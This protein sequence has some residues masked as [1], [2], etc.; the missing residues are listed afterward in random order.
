MKKHSHKFWHFTH[1]SNTYTTKLVYSWITKNIRHFTH[2]SNTYTT[3]LIYSWIT[4]NIRA[5]HRPR[6]KGYRLLGQLPGVV[7]TEQCPFPVTCHSCPLWF[8]PS[9]HCRL[10]WTLL[11]ACAM[12]LCS[13]AV[14]TI[15]TKSVRRLITRYRI[16]PWQIKYSKFFQSL[17]C[18]SP[19][20]K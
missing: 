12:S 18:K 15:N 7:Q 17:K 14:P 8:Q 11:S 10:I 9:P 2:H 20:Q 6:R 1:H 13:P 5:I 4:K 3:K 16:T 19:N